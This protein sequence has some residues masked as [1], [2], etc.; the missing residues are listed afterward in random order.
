ML[1]APEGAEASPNE[2]LLTGAKVE[3]VAEFWDSSPT[4][5]LPST[6]WAWT[7]LPLFGHPALQHR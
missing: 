6:A 3:S 7:V 1:G 4:V 2:D 5:D